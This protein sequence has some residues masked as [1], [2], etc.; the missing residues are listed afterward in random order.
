[1]R[2]DRATVDGRNGTSVQQELTALGFDEIKR[3]LHDE[4]IGMVHVLSRD[5]QTAYE[6]RAVRPCSDR[7]AEVAGL[8]G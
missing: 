8:R 3:R 5:R 2:D 4:V 6:E 1:M 7:W